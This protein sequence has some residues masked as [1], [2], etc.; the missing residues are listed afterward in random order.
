MMVRVLLVLYP[1]ARTVDVEM[2]Q[3]QS[4]KEKT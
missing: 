3:A 1:A 4:R 2:N